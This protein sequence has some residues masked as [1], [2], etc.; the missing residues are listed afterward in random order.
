M[1]RKVLPVLI[2]QLSLRTGLD[3][4]CGLGHFSAFLNSLGFTVTGIDGRKENVEEAV[5]RVPNATFHT[6]DIE[7]PKLSDIG[8][9]DLVLCFGLLYHLENPFRAIR[10]LHSLTDKVLLV[11]SMCAPGVDASMELLDEYQKEDQGLTYVAFYPTEACLVKMLYRAGFPFVYGF[12]N[13]PDHADFQSTKGRKRARTMLVAS[14][15][16]LDV[17]GLVALPEPARPWDIWAAPTLSWRTRL[18][19]LANIVRSP[20]TKRPQDNQDAAK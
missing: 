2:G 4:G 16:R 19:R 14:N 15:V 3:A 7:D 12:V 13:P 9:F 1:V 17:A 11:E 5:R 6:R 8:Q 10:N 20:G 18:R